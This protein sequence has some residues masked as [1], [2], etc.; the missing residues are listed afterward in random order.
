MARSQYCDVEFNLQVA[1]R[2]IFVSSKPKSFF[3]K[4]HE[5]KTLAGGHVPGKFDHSACWPS[6]K[7]KSKIW[8]VIL[9]INFQP[10]LSIAQL[11]Q[12]SFSFRPSK[13]LQ[14]CAIIS[15]RSCPL[16]WRDAMLT[17]HLLTYE[18]QKSSFFIRTLNGHGK[19]VSRIIMKRHQLFSSR[20][21]RNSTRLPWAPFC[22][23]HISAWLDYRHSEAPTSFLS[24]WSNANYRVESNCFVL[25][26]DIFEIDCKTRAIIES[27]Q[28]RL[29]SYA[30]VNTPIHRHKLVDQRKYLFLKRLEINLVWGLSKIYEFLKKL[31][32]MFASWLVNVAEG[33]LFLIQTKNQ[34]DWEAKRALRVWDF[35]SSYSGS[36]WLI[37]AFK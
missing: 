31:R 8:I 1:S 6:W 21:R 9:L 30:N 11:A 26:S 34:F 15:V 28:R 37:K 23:A 20:T 32:W 13:Y 35:V 24:L 25:E 2:R 36:S 12:K 22:K 33:L 19:E 5:P 29:I 7:A 4:T 3:R 18:T 10:N 14:I 16:G 27:T 17:R